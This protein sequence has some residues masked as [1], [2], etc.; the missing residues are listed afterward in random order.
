MT[1]PTPTTRRPGFAGFTLV[2]LLVVI[3]IIG[4]LLGVLLP[5]VMSARKRAKQTA[6]ASNLRQVYTMFLQYAQEFDDNLPIG[7][8]VKC[9]TDPENLYRTDWNNFIRVGGMPGPAGGPILQSGRF[10]RENAKI[11]HC[12]LEKREYMTWDAV[13]ERY[14]LKGGTAYGTIAISY[15]VRPVQKIWAWARDCGPGEGIG[16]P[17]PMAKLDQF[18]GKAIL[19][20][21]PGRP[22]FNHGTDQEP[23]VH[24]AMQDGSVKLVQVRGLGG[25]D[26]AGQPATQFTPD[27]KYGLGGVWYEEVQEPKAS[28]K[29]NDTGLKAW[30][31]LDKQ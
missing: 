23:A 31:W 13:E 14:P 22:P 29:P 26:K 16:W 17:R 8:T 4:I 3:G 6:C 11:L 27:A 2:E 25:M 30:E 5:A 10:F 18:L 19:A 24:V 28:S 9:V 20:E 12:P 1:Q 7:T 21:D 15:S